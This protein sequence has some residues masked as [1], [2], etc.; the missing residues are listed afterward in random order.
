LR[1]R[2]PATPKRCPAIEGIETAGMKRAIALRQNVWVCPKRKRLLHPAAT[3]TNEAVRG[4]P[5]TGW[6]DPLDSVWALTGDDL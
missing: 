4:R 3:T 1:L 5:R 6:G 2:P